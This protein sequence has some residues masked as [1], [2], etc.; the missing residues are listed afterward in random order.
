MSDTSSTPP[1][2]CQVLIIGAGPAGSA[3]A[4]WL[5]PAG[6]DVVFAGQ[7]PLGRDKDCGGG[8]IPDAHQALERLGL[9]D[10]VMAKAQ[11]SAHVGCVG[12]RGGRIDVP[13]HLAVLPRR[14]LDELLNLGAQEAGAR[15]LAP[16]RFEAALED[17]QGRV[18]GAR[19]SIDGQP[20]EIAADW[21]I[22]ATGAV[23]KALTAAGMCE[24]HTPS[25]VA[26]RGY[27]RAP[28]MV[29]EI[30]ALEVVW[31]KPVQ[32]G[33]GWIFPAPDGSFNIGVG[34]TDSHQDL[35]GKGQKKDVNLRAIFDAFGAP[36]PPAK[37]LM[38]EGELIGELKGAPLRC[39]L[40]G[41][42]WTRPGLLVTGEAAG[43]TYSFTGEGIGKA[44]ET[45][46]LAA[47]A[48]LAH[49]TGVDGFDA[50]VRAQYEQ[51]LRALQPKY[52]LYERGNRVNRFPWLA[53]LLIWRAKK[54]PRLLQ[55]MSGVLNETSNP[56]NLV[57]L[58]GITRLF[59]E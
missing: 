10:R 35:A 4:R 11:R 1:S 51:G 5:A 49:G 7:Q 32:P 57:S 25:G 22:L 28:S 12:P 56:G 19:F 34:V 50:K 16:A 39:T 47:E 20:H 43:S 14:Q 15:F 55:R 54:S 59:L 18:R 45:G 38:A 30:K 42:R 3:A 52:D 33:Y 41:A 27:V 58:K 9:L 17:A 24:R 44:M 26:L 36:Y 37:R 8:L 13:G 40:K 2:R 46:L 21:V 23:P 48:I 53:D 31:C 6:G 29:G